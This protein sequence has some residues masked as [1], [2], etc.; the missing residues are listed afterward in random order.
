MIVEILE[1]HNIGLLIFEIQV[2]F[3]TS[4]V[5]GQQNLYS[6]M[7]STRLE[8]TE[9]PLHLKEK[10]GKTIILFKGGAPSSWPFNFHIG[11]GISS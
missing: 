3:S 10:S 4:V 6:E 9:R 5:R 1:S 11:E 7:T 2:F 8:V